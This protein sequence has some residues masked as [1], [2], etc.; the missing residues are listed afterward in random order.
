MQTLITLIIGLIGGFI[1]HAVAMKVSFKKSDRENKMKVY[2]GIIG[3]WLT[4]RNYIFANHPE[5][6]T[7]PRNDY[8]HTFDQMYGQSQKFIGETI[9][10]SD[11]EKL[12]EDINRLTEMFYRTDWNSL[13]LET[14]NR[15][16]ED[17][18]IEAIDLVKRMR[19]DAK[20]STVFHWTD[21]A[22]IVTG[23]F[24]K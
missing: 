8:V 13:S 2:D 11:G 9:L 10:I 14:V 5:T 6:S 22:H 20:N 7:G 24:C 4:M 17:I 21:L 15:N 19:N 16:M 18:K 23:F 12:F 1:A 3:V